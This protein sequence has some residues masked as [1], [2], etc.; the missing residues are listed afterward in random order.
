MAGPGEADRGGPRELDL[1]LALEI[2]PEDTATGPEIAREVRDVLTRAGFAVIDVEDLSA[3]FVITV[4]GQIVASRL[5][6]P[7][8][9]ERAAAAALSLAGEMRQWQAAYVTGQPRATI[10][11]VMLWANSAAEV[12]AA[13]GDAIRQ[14]T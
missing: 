7:D 8:G 13:L 5:V 9:I 14:V 11:D 2:D 12:L 1:H 4:P 3:G 10:G 6:L